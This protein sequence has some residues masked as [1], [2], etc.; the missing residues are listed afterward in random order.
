MKWDKAA[1]QFIDALASSDATPGGGA[2]AAMTGAMGC[3]LALMAV[4]TTLKRKSTP[5][6]VL[7]K[8]SDSYKRLMSFK[9]ELQSYILKDG[10]AYSSY[11]TAKK[12]PKQDDNRQNALEQALWF[13]A[14]VPADTATAALHCLREID[15]I[16]SDV[17]EVIMSDIL[18]ARHLLQSCIKCSV[19]NMRANLVFITNKDHVAALE[20]QI[21]TF[22][23]SC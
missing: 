8:L 14:R 2:G 4:G 20:K 1:N 21:A 6:S 15:L 5:P 10:E 22:L 7:P 3:A 16:K 12:L 19:E 23:K 17:A 18:C 13:A 9:D 11:L